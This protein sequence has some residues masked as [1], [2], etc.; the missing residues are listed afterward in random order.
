M[1]GPVVPPVVV[2]EALVRR[3]AGPC[4]ALTYN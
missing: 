4:S 1:L 3:N 2:K